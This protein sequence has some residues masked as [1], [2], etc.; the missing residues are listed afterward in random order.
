M[1]RAHAILGAVILGAAAV[2]FCTSPAA[3][4]ERVGGPI[5]TAQTVGP[6]QTLSFEM[7][8]MAGKRAMVGINGN[9]ATV[10]DL[11]VF[12]GNGNV[13]IGRGNGDQKAIYFNVFR[14]GTFRIEV[15]NLGQLNNTF[16]L[17]TN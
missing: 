2:V 12:D 6:N 3:K 5:T 15:R 4:G 1:K 13:M 16:Y 14:T 10:L 17:M 11:R 9:N 8:F 7:S